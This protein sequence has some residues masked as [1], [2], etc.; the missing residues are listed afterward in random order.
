[1]I[2]A[3][4]KFPADY[5]K[6]PNGAGGKILNFLSGISTAIAFLAWTMGPSAALAQERTTGSTPT[7]TESGATTSLTRLAE[8]TNSSGMRLKLI[9]TGS[10]TMGSPDTELDRN[11]REDP[12]WRYPDEAPQHKVTIT[13]P[14]YLGICEV[15]QA[16]YEKVMGVNPS[17]FVGSKLPVE[18]VSWQ[19]AQAFCKRL[20]EI[21]NRQYRL[22][23]EAEW[24]YACRAGTNTAYYWGG[25]YESGYAW[26][27]ENSG[28]KTHKVGTLK[29]NTWGLHDMAGNV[30][31]WCQDRKGPYSALD[32]ENPGGSSSG[33]F[34]VLRGGSWSDYPLPFRCAA[35][36]GASEDSLIDMVGFRVVL[37]P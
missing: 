5:G 31:E 32:Q 21:E 34:R 33:G 22:P 26:V 19:D 35:R 37:D 9:P 1:M 12:L 23:T 3:N 17:N 28:N 7:R 24:E 25:D 36:Y 8:T 16:E 18:K 29:P 11:R 27:N 13:K 15:T 2:V 10:F 30:W 14:F 4:D 6:L 20:S